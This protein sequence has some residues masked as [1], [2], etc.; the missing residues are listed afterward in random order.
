MEAGLI[1]VLVKGRY[2]VVREATVR[3]C[4]KGKRDVLNRPLQKLIPLEVK[5]EDSEGNMEFRVETEERVSRE[6]KKVR[7][8]NE[9]VRGCRPQRAAAKDARWK[10]RLAQGESRREVC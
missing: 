10:T 9:D 5:R 4:S 6:K 8:L 2:G 3:V 1:E 7:D